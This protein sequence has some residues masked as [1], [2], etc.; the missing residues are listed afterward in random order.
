MNT[1][2]EHHLYGFSPSTNFSPIHCLGAKP[3]KFGILE[4][5]CWLGWFHE[6]V[7]WAFHLF[8]LWHFVGHRRLKALNF[9]SQKGLTL[10]IWVHHEVL[11][12]QKWMKWRYGWRII[13][14][15][16]DTTFNYNVFSFM[17][18]PL[19]LRLDTPHQKRTILTSQ[20]IR[21]PEPA[22]V[23]SPEVASST[24]HLTPGRARCLPL[25]CAHW[26]E[27]PCKTKIYIVCPIT[28]AKYH[29]IYI[30]FDCEL[31]K[32]YCFTITGVGVG[33]VTTKKN[34]LA[35]LMKTRLSGIHRFDAFSLDSSFANSG[36]NDSSNRM[37]VNKSCFAYSVCLPL[38]LWFWY[39]RNV[40][41]STRIFANFAICC[42]I[43]S[44][45]PV[46][47]SSIRR[48]VH[49]SLMPLSDTDSVSSDSSLAPFRPFWPKECAEWQ[50]QQ[51]AHSELVRLHHLLVSFLPFLRTL[52]TSGSSAEAVRR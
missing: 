9:R 24:W 27:P 40:C 50:E 28:S 51:Q 1:S 44:T 2:S 10:S 17:P 33:K 39:M 15:D 43:W 47:P 45:C 31:Q 37:D 46:S 35:S 21:N 23:L 5:I 52:Q 12:R 25:P 13:K 48:K 3:S 42:S 32:C 14:G 8:H 41:V 26:R 36:H 22:T 29:W 7:R 18:C 49:T 38:S 16:I 19:Q 6:G 11:A 34:S 4:G 20:H 30:I